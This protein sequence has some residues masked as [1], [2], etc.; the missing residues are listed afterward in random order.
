MSEKVE[1]NSPCLCQYMQLKITYPRA[2]VRSFYPSPH[3]LVLLSEVLLPLFVTYIY[4][5]H[6]DILIYHIVY[7]Q[8]SLTE[9]IHLFLFSELEIELEG[10]IFYD[11]RVADW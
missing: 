4:Y 8:H 3:L 11:G 5:I 10:N 6:T 2:T 9:C 7:S 1:V